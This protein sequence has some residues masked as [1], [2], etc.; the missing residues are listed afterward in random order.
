MKI[1]T[2]HSTSADT[3]TATREAYE[4][5][6]AQLGNTP[7]VLL[8]HASAGHGLDVI[9]KELARLA[10]D[11]PLHGGTSSRGGMT[12][13]GHV[14]GA[15]SKAGLVMWGA[16][17][18]AGAFGVAGGDLSDA[19]RAAASEA[20]RRAVRAAG[21]AGEQPDL[22]WLTAAPGFEEEV[23][24]GITD[25]FGGDVPVIGGS[26]ADDDVLGQWRQLADGQMYEGGLAVTVMFLSSR[27]GVSFHSGYAV[28]EHRGVVTRASGRTIHEIDGR[29]AAQV[30]DEW[31]GG[32]LGALPNG[33]GSAL[34]LTTMTPL[35]TFRGGE[36]VRVLLHPEHVDSDGSLRLFANIEE[37][38][39]VALMRGSEDALATRATRV[40]GAA[41]ASLE[42]GSTPSGALVIYC[43]GCMMAIESRMDEVASGI[44]QEL[45][46]AP[47]LGAF[48]FGEQGCL[49]DHGNRHGN[50]MISAVVFGASP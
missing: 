49:V 33:G 38:E 27:P 29:P 10:P 22:V 2:G 19:P 15:E 31:S 48:S 43:A 8:V 16:S 20:V 26:S 11:V 28:T 13:A 32:V 18:P 30:Y 9:A 5:L 39:E 7:D 36:D 24:D 44:D 47:F 40:V 21:R 45:A 14:R 1:E 6:R 12:N 4:Q 46:G 34:A 50:L 42:L 3:V 37:G 41:R 25:V 17:D 23:L 35:G